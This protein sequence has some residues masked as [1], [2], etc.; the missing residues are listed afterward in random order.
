MEKVSKCVRV[1]VMTTVIVVV[2]LVIN[3]M[4][5][6]RSLFNWGISWFNNSPME[7]GW[8]DNIPHI[9]SSYTLTLPSLVR[10]MESLLMSRWMTPC[11]CR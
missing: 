4:D 1:C 9:N 5:I 2:A 6:L 3:T 10:R 8:M 7:G 11:V